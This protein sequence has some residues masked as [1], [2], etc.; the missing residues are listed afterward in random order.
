M[1]IRDECG[2]SDDDDMN[3]LFCDYNDMDMDCLFCG[4]NDGELQPVDERE[5]E[6]AFES[7]LKS[8]FGGRRH[9]VLYWSDQSEVE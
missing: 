8:V 9:A 2:Y 7:A 5:Y 1:C 4:Y 6:A 3:C